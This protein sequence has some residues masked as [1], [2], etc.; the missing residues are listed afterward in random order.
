MSEVRIT[1]ASLPKTSSSLAAACARA[2][3]GMFRMAWR[4][5]KPAV[6]EHSS[7][8]EHQSTQTFKWRHLYVQTPSGWLFARSSTKTTQYGSSG[9]YACGKTVPLREKERSGNHARN[10][11]ENQLFASS[12]ACTSKSGR[13][14]VGTC[15]YTRRHTCVSMFRVAWRQRRPAVSEHSSGHEHQSTQT[16]K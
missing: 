14:C 5:R 8:H 13:S 9:L 1:E 11:T 7:S 12:C 16:F 10:C 6:S 3:H 15:M 4:Q 2:S